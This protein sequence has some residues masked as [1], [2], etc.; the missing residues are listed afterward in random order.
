[1][2]TSVNSAGGTVSNNFINLGAAITYIDICKSLLL[3][4]YKIKILLIFWDGILV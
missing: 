3:Y 1:M 4:D 2:V